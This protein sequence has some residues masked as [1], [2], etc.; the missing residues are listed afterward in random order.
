MKAIILAAGYATRLFPL[1]QNFPKPLIPINNKTMMDYIMDKISQ[2]NIDE[3]FVVTNNKYF[4]HFQQRKNQSNYD[5][6]IQIINDQTMSND[7]RLGALG[8]T[9]YII[10]QKNID[11]DIFVV[12]GDNLFE[13]SLEPTYNLF[14]E[15]NKV[16]IAGFDVQSL[17]IAK[18]LWIFAIDTDQK[19][20]EFVE[21]PANPPSTL[22]ST[23][24]YF[25]PKEIVKIFKSY[26]EDGNNTD[27]PGSFLAR[28]IN[29]DEVY[30]K[31]YTDQ[32]YDV[33]T[34]E[35]LVAAKQKFG[36]T[37][38]DINQLKQGILN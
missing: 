14:K 6:A 37:N 26:I 16:T 10:E 28:L 20:T 9:Q 34:F 29:K 38:V 11:D 31:I 35:N 13:F 5:I 8:D 4:D 7:D 17:D 15:K 21:K 27:T 19:I 32:R 12:C 23:G 24:I 2:I 18:K 33:G 1:T 25:Y 22:A 30:A 3:I 36:E